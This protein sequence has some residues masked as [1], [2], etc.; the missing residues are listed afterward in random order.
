MLEGQTLANELGWAGLDVTMGVDMALFGWLS[1][2]R[3]LLVGADSV[4]VSGLV[5][6]IGTTQLALAAQRLG[7]PCIAVCTSH[8]MLPS[9]YMIA[10]SLRAGDPE[11]IMPVS[12][13]NITVRNAYFDVTPLDLFATIITEEGPLGQAELFERLDAVRTYPGLR[14]R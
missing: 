4:S 3:A 6:K 1:D 7:I 14:G 11:E 10:Q 12:N 9:D 8:K 5:N 2:T 13:E